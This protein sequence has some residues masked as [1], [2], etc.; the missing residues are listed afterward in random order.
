MTERKGLKEVWEI[1]CE[2]VRYVTEESWISPEEIEDDELYQLYDSVVNAYLTY[3]RLAD[4]F[5]GLLDEKV[6][7]AG[8][9][10]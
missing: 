2:G 5:G 4:E 3:E 9:N 1:F 7:E 6:R 10:E 8:L